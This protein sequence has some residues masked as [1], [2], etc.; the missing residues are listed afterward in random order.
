M[1]KDPEVNENQTQRRSK[2]KK[3]ISLTQYEQDN[4]TNPNIDSSYISPQLDTPH[5]PSSLYP[6]QHSQSPSLEETQATL[7]TISPGYPRGYKE[8]EPEPKQQ[9]LQQYAG[10]MDV[11]ERF[12]EI[13]KPIFVEEKKKPKII[14]SGQFKHY[15]NKDG[16][17]FF[18]PPKNYRPT[19]IPRPKNLNLSEEQWNQFDGD[20]REG[21]VLYCL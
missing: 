7:R 2:Q 10:L 11:I 19:L 9:K 15:S 20:V 13:M 16:P 3:P 17:L 18:Y 1:E 6:Q 8:K 12:H 5:K 21:V 4:Q 14:L